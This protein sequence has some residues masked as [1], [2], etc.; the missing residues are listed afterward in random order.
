M[1]GRFQ[2]KSTVKTLSAAPDTAEFFANIKDALKRKR[3]PL[4][5]NDVRIAAHAMESGSQRITLDK[6]FSLIGGLLV[7][8]GLSAG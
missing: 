4:P 2:K 1:S 6:H 8:N 7:W 5:I 3:P